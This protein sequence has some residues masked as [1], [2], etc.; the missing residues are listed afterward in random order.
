MAGTTVQVRGTGWD[1]SSDVDAAVDQVNLVVA[2]LEVLRGVLAESDTLIE[3]LHDDHA[4]FK[5]VVDDLKTLLNAVRT[6]A[7]NGICA[8]NPAFVI[9]TNFDVK[10]TNA[11][12]VMVDGQLVSCAANLSFDTGTTATTAT[13]TFIG[14][15]L[16]VAADGTTTSIDWGTTGQASA[17]AAIATLGAVSPTQAAVVG[18][19]VVEAHAANSWTA[20]TDALTTGTGGNVANSTTYWQ[21]RNPDAINVGAAVST[22]SPAT[23]AASKPTSASVNAAGDMTAALITRTLG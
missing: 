3:E 23:L 22:S 21:G 17:A 19:V 15:V 5:T 20:G 18:Y 16:S 6:M 10:A 14:G 4:T 8:G 2:D 1:G 7:L 9:D 11:F 12:Q 13:A